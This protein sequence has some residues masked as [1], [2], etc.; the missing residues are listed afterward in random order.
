[1]TVSIVGGGRYN[2]GIGSSADPLYMGDFAT[3]AGDLYVTLFKWAGSDTDITVYNNAASTFDYLTKRSL[4][5]LRYQ[6]ATAKELGT[7]AAD[8]VFAY[9]AA[10]RDGREV[11]TFQIRGLVTDAPL[12]SADNVGSVSSGTALTLSGV[13]PG[14]DGGIVVGIYT[15]SADPGPLT[16][17]NGFVLGPDIFGSKQRTAMIYKTAS[18]GGSLVPSLSWD[19]ASDALGTSLAFAAL[20]EEPQTYVT[21]YLDESG[22][23][24]SNLT[25]FGWT[26]DDPSTELA[27]KWTGI[28]PENALDP[29]GK[30]A[31]RIILPWAPGGTT[32]GQS[33][34]LAARKPGS[35][36]VSSFFFPGIV[37]GTAS[38]G[39]IQTLDSPIETLTMQRIINSMNRSAEIT[40]P[41]FPEDPNGIYAD[42]EGAFKYTPDY[43]YRYF[44]AWYVVSRAAGGHTGPVDKLWLATRCMFQACYTG[45]ST[46][47][48]SRLITGQPDGALY[49]HAGDFVRNP[50]T[51]GPNPELMVHPGGPSY[52]QRIR[53]SAIDNLQYHC[54]GAG[55]LG[56]GASGSETYD[57]YDF[58]VTGVL[59]RLEGDTLADLAAQAPGCRL[60]IYASGDFSQKISGPM[61]SGSFVDEHGHGIFYRVDTTWRWILSVTRRDGTTYLKPI[62]PT[63]I[64]QIN[65]ELAPL[66]AATPP[67]VP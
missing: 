38:P 12:V 1:M 44:L 10:A 8:Q 67:V 48:L 17:G 9:P 62:N 66:L 57:G 28:A 53:V 65:D 59:A 54:W 51:T 11:V 56:P 63:V 29:E 13:D 37:T 3:Q 45:T 55:A 27:T 5:T 46:P 50:T 33:L 31:A 36:S 52:G 40:M 41:H 42:T 19:N 7:Q 64:A 43:A 25:V 18:A 32:D 6:I 61:I 23:G 30:A 22:R 39:Q 35:D 14:S 26:T 4:S 49:A 15:F 2:A 20:A 24:E 47:V 16:P 58:I 21:G 34:N 60:A